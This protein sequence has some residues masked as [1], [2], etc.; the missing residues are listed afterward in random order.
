MRLFFFFFLFTV[1]I[2]QLSRLRLWCTSSEATENLSSLNKILIEK[3]LLTIELIISAGQPTDGSIL[4]ISSRTEGA[5][6]LLHGLQAPHS[7]I[8]SITGTMKM[9]SH[10]AL[11]TELSTKDEWV[12]HF[13]L[14]NLCVHHISAAMSMVQSRDLVPL[15]AK[16]LATSFTSLKITLD[17]TTSRQ[18]RV[19]LEF[20]VELDGGLP[21]HRS[22]AEELERVVAGRADCSLEVLSRAEPSITIGVVQSIS[23]AVTPSRVS[24]WVHLDGRGEVSLDLQEVPL[25]RLVTGTTAYALCEDAALKVCSEWTHTGNVAHA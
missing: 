20:L 24:S 17:R 22:L 16:L 7:V 2:A 15:L 5:I 4:Q 18:M 1:G 8:D 25:L 19:E 3:P 6:L 23:S 12:V 13:P 14:D 21:E 11:I 9:R 10:G